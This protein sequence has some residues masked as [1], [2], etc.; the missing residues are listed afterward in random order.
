[1]N[2]VVS[3]TQLSYDI[4]SFL[5]TTQGIW[6]KGVF[7]SLFQLHNFSFSKIN[8]QFAFKKGVEVA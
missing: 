5:I 4:N 7:F 3:S 8:F 2:L 6:V 1:L